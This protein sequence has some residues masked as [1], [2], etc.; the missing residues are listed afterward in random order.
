MGIEIREGCIFEAFDRGIVSAIAHQTNVDGA[1]GAGIAREI[2]ARYPSVLA[3]FKALK[4]P[5]LGQVLASQLKDNRL[6]FNV[7]A[8]SLFPRNELKKTNYEALYN[9]FNTVAQY[10]A[11]TNIRQI[12][13]PYNLGCGL[14]GGN[15][16]VVKAIFNCLF[17]NNDRTNLIIFE[18]NV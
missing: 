12:G 14:G 7:Y 1:M 9:G 8:Q 11:K 3:D 16:G 10:C 6:V 2:A 15:W 5:M 18:K 4:S 13:V 17:E